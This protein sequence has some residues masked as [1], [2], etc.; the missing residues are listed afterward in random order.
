MNRKSTRKIPDENI[1]RALSDAGGKVAA[2]ARILNCERKT[3]YNHLRKAPELQWEL[4][5][6]RAS[7]Y[8]AAFYK[9]CERADAG[10]IDA[11][12]YY[13]RHY[14]TGRGYGDEKDRFP[15]PQELFEHKADSKNTYLITR[16][17]N[18]WE[19]KVF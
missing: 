13:L 5:E 6:Y 8:E 9:L 3:I 1:S 14:G 19:L 2:A 16:K 4:D 15:Y 7:I 12:I 10:D 18:S 11:C 17:L